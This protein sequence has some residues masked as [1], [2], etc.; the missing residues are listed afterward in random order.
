VRNEE[1]V[2]TVAATDA[3]TT[4][5]FRHAQYGPATELGA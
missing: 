2:A 5:G 4:G 1:G 3:L